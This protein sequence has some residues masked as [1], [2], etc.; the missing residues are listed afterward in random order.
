LVEYCFGILK[1]H[2]EWGLGL[3]RKQFFHFREKRK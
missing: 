1:A 3:K 2:R